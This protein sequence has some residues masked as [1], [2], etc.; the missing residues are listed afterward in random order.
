MYAKGGGGEEGLEGETG[1]PVGGEDLGDGVD[2]GS[3][4]KSRKQYILYDEQ[5]VCAIL[6][7][8]EVLNNLCSMLLTKWVN[9]LKVKVKKI[10]QDKNCSVY[11]LKSYPVNIQ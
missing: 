3:S 5:L 9:G 8:H 7:V 11:L 10:L 4:S 6:Y 1:V 2:V